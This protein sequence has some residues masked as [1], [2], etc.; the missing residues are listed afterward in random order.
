MRTFSPMTLLGALGVLSMVASP[1]MAAV[2]TSEWKCETC[3]FEKAG[4]SGTVDAGIANVSE[5][6]AKFGEFSG[7]DRKGA[8][9]FGGADVRYQGAGGQYGAL[10]ADTDV[11]AL[12]AQFGSEGQYALRLGYA[13]IPHH[14][15]DD[16]MT[17]F[18]GVGSADLTLPAGFRSATA[19]AMP[20][21][22][23]LHSVELGTTRSRY[24][25]GLTFNT[26]QHWTHTVTLRRDVRDGTQ[27]MSGSFFATAAQLVAPVDQVTNQL[28]VST[29]YTTRKMQASLSY[30]V[31]L[32]T[33]DHSSLTW[34]NPFT[35]G[36]TGTSRGQLA[37][38]PDNQFHQLLG[39]ASYEVL[40]WIRASG[41]LAIGR[42]TQDA[43]LLPAT[44]NP[45][46]A[47]AIPALPESSLNG[48]VDSFN[49]N[50]RFAIRA[51]DRLRVNASYSRDVRQNR[52]A[53]ESFPALEA[54][55]FLGSALR[56][57]QPFTFKQDRY[58]LQADYRA[59]GGVKLSGGVQENDVERSRQDT[60][61]TRDTSA[62][63]R[64]GMQ[65]RPDLSV[66]MKLAHSERSNSGYGSATWVTPAENSLMR[67]YN[68]ADRRRDAASLRADMNIAEGLAIGLNVDAS[69]DKYA[70]TTVGL[71]EGRSL[72]FG[73]DVSWVVSD[74]T[75]LRAF[76]Q[77]ER[78]R[79]SQ[80]GSSSATQPDWWAQ[81]KDAIDVVGVGVKQLALKGKLEL[82]ADLTYTRS[83]SDALID[84]G[85]SGPAFP[86]ASTSL[87][88][89]K[90]N[91]T[92]HLQQNL[93]LTGGFWFE[94]YRSRD[95]KLDGVLPA[96]VGNLLALGE[97]SPRYHLYLLRLG[98]RYRF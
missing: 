15:S 2:D 67:K 1:A 14:V 66:S 22:T 53:S 60:V 26:G 69:N 80:A 46:L 72:S 54:D 97:Q 88:S 56:S 82:G 95:W 20:L 58:K 11:G 59:P 63:G 33:N 71:T 89:V 90:F 29:Q 79:S 36:G 13:S 74:A 38:A 31:S 5:R 81:N 73:G 55:M 57:N 27:R 87:D 94:D 25:L 30:Q 84:A 65:V 41:D 62:W 16:A 51:S 61:T 19:G 4:V 92:Y 93:S 37:L 12:K 85:S 42:L 18:A 44:L 47:L 91:A 76:A 43:A 70:N 48:K 8:Q 78:Q 21:S 28:Q 23:T 50:A 10:V 49:G 45:T 17:P 64:V 6:S 34:S 7:L 32:F 40:P 83:R 96:T 9:V 77:A 86:R 35:E 24:D 39:T 68:L 3:P 52:T 75:Q 98:V